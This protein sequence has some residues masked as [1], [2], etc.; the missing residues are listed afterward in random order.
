LQTKYENIEHI[1]LETTTAC[2]LKCPLCLRENIEFENI[3][4]RSL[5]EI[6]SDIL[7]FKN[8]KKITLSSAISEPTTFKDILPLIEFIKSLNII[9]EIFTN[10]DLHDEKWWEKL[11]NI[12]SS[13][14]SITFTV[15]GSTQELHEKYRVNSN[16]D[17]VIRNILAFEKINPINCVS[18]LRFKYNEFD[19]LSV[20]NNKFNE[21]IIN[22][23]AQFN[24]YVY[25]KDNEFNM[26]DN[27]RKKYL[28]I[29][30]INKDK[31]IVCPAKLDNFLIINCDGSLSPCDLFKMQTK[32]TF[33]LDFTNIENGNYDF[34][35]ECDINTQKLLNII[36]GDNVWM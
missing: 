6:K 22:D 16:L 2:N 25:N 3:S 36:N 17:T 15:C 8:V 30:K 13:N 10:G 9:V 34:C 28:N 24:E 14:D 1:E 35:R 4:S 20:Y 7:K 18:Y 31:N 27:L 11:A 19:D 32:D 33:N 12:M 26:V 21:F 5:T 23:T 29:L